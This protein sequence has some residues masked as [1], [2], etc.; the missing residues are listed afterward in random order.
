[1]EIDL[2]DD[3]QEEGEGEG[4]GKQSKRE[5]GDGMY[6][7]LWHAC[8]GPHISL[9]KKGS[10]VVYFPQGHLEQAQVASSASYCPPHHSL[11]LSAHALPPQVFCRVVDVHLLV[12]V[13][14]FAYIGLPF[15]SLHRSC[16]L[17][18]HM[19][20][21]HAMVI[22]IGIQAEKENDEVYARLTLSPITEVPCLLFYLVVAQITLQF[23]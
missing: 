16:H 11:G 8:A 19:F 23:Y 9:P 6:M 20:T 2:N 13:L 17:N 12:S 22:L 15:C 18:I 1:M 10:L 3:A 21:V 5:D 14:S 7:E 4:S